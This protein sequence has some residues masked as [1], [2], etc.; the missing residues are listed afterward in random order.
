M[1][2]KFKSFVTSFKEREDG[3]TSVEFA[4]G[5]PIV[6]FLFL[7]AMDLGIMSTKSVILENAVDHTIRDL[8][9]GTLKATSSQPLKEQICKLAPILDDCANNIAIELI[10]INT[11]V[12]NLPANDSQCVDRDAK[13]S[14]PLTFNVG[15]Q[16]QI[17]LIRVCVI[18]E[19]TFKTIGIGEEIEKD[20]GGGFGMIAV[21]AFVNEPK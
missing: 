17:M 8:R 1:I 11:T 9:L 13:I 16:N 7:T 4:V 21:S 15:R 10:P 14:P 2:R 3:I 18:V 6:F 20:Q 12:W 19:P 5:F